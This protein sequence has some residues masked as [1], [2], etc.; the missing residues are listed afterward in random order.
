MGVEAGTKDGVEFL[1]GGARGSAAEPEAGTQDA[2]NVSTGAFEEWDQW[3]V[4]C[5]TTENGLEDGPFPEETSQGNGFEP[6]TE[7]V[8]ATKR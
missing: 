1:G 3:I 2:E 4:R 8:V 7:T 6:V 5:S